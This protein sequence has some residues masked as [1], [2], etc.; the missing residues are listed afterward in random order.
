MSGH[1][2]RNKLI[3]KIRE[4]NC[5]RNI[6]NWVASC[7]TCH[8]RKHPTYLRRAEL[9]PMI[10]QYP[11]QR[12]HTDIL[13][14]FPKS[15]SGKEYVVLMIDAFTKY[16]SAQA[17]ENQKA[18]TIAQVLYDEIYTRLGAPKIIVSDMRPITC[19]K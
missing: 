7:L 16:V 17:V 3:K 4:R 12:L 9:Q 2:G 19:P 8:G 14:P 1:C 15:I 10:S 11:L 5:I 18:E 6:R 13:G